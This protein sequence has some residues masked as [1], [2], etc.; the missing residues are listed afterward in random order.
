MDHEP[1]TSRS[2]HRPHAEKSTPSGPTRRSFLGTTAGVGAAALLAGGR[3]VRAATKSGRVLGANDRIQLG[4][5][6]TGG[7]GREHIRC[8]IKNNT[9]VEF[10]AIC[11]IYEKNMSKALE[12]FD[13]QSKPHPKLLGEHEK[14]LDMQEID[15]V[16]IASPDHWHMRHL[17][18]TVSAGKDA[19]CEKPMSLS[20][21]QGNEM[22]KAVRATDRIVQVGMQRRSSPPV[23]EAKKIIDS[24]FLGEVSLVRAHWYWH[25]QEALDPSKSAINGKLDWDRFQAPLPQEKHRAVDAL[26]FHRWRY[27]WDYSGGNMTDQGTHLMDVIQWYF[28][29]SKP[30]AA[31]I[32]AGNVYQLKAYETPD[33]F[34]AVFEY[35]KFMAT[36]T[37]TYTNNYQNGWGIVAHGSKGTLELGDFGARFY[38]NDAFPPTWYKQPPPTPKHE[39]VGGL[40]VDLHEK[41]FFECM[42]TRQE[43]NAPVEIGHQAVSALH[44]A[45]AAHHA[46]RRV[47]LDPKTYKIA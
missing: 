33:T 34:C 17:V 40:R 13:A 5:I 26:R 1:R 44:L 15:G 43:P 2:T 21:P 37:L 10:V 41:N 6:G 38:D 25:M 3:K 20:I 22:V 19:Y 18:E 39:V 7:M 47:T 23:M 16:I 24:G 28:N 42:R 11:D 9:D 4:I 30:P 8:I 27:F 32:E 36:W 29:D 46:G 35:P 12:V 14:L 31:A 45:N